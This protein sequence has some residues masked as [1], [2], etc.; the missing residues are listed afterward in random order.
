MTTVQ[1]EKSE[2]GVL[3][4][5]TLVLQELGGKYE[6]C[7]VVTALGSLATIEWSE[8]EIVAC[9]L[10]FRTHEHNGQVYMDVIANEM[11]YIKHSWQSQAAKPSE[12][13]NIKHS[14]LSSRL[15]EAHGEIS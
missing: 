12:R 1:S 14:F 15:S 13:L 7:Y 5:R 10:S 6:N 9:A 8:G 11:Y 3:D 4:K 2:N